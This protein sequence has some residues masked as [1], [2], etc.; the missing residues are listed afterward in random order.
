MDLVVGSEAIVRLCVLAID[1]CRVV[2]TSFADATT[3]A[4]IWI[5]TLLDWRGADQ[6]DDRKGNLEQA[7]EMHLEQAGQIDQG[8]KGTREG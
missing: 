4:Y 8:C 2:Q 1:D 3:S 5:L 6:T 7:G